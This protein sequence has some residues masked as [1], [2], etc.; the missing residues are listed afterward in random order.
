VS[1]E[2]EKE[3]VLLDYQILRTEEQRQ[4]LVSRQQILE[5]KQEN[6]RQIA[7]QKQTLN[8]KLQSICNENEELILKSELE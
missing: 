7:Q 5:F 2:L 1:T 3:G 6:L 8:K 4:L